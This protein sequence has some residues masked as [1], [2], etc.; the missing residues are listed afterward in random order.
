MEKGE[1]IQGFVERIQ[2]K[3]ESGFYEGG[4]DGD[5][6]KRLDLGSILKVVWIRFVMGMDVGCEREEEV[7]DVLGLLV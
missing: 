7:M 1:I 6:G 2:W 3:R 5:N 4:S